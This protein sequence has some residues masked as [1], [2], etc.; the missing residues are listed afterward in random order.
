MDPDRYRPAGKLY[1][2]RKKEEN[3]LICLQRD[4]RKR[5]GRNRLHIMTYTV[6]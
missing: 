3:K 5:K 1:N 6:T 2:R 4:E